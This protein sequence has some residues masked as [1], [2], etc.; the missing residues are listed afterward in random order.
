MKNDLIREVRKAVHPMK[1]S[2]IILYGNREGRDRD[3]LIVSSNDVF[4][5]RIVSGL[6]DIVVVGEKYLLDLVRLFDPIVVEPILEGEVL[7]GKKVWEIK[8]NILRLISTNSSV[9]HLDA[10]SRHILEGAIYFFEK[11]DYEKS[12]NNVLFSLSYK[13]LSRY[14][15]GGKKAITFKEILILRRETLLSECYLYIKSEKCYLSE[16]V[17]KFL[18]KAKKEILY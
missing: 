18:E 12:I 6:L 17:E 16:D 5:E 13:E 2:T 1:I 7:S 9:A 10:F 4:I 3:I 11:G 8:K 14:Y 15:V